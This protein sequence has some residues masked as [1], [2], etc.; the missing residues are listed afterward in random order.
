MNLAKN[1]DKYDI[2]FLEI[3]DQYAPKGMR[4]DILDHPE[5]L[6]KAYKSYLSERYDEIKRGN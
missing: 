3:A 2:D 4:D 5:E 6:Q 1:N